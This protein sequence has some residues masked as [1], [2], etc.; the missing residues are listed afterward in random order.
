MKMVKVEICRGTS[1]H[2]LGSQDLI[3]AVES[4]P[5]DRRVQI[6]LGTIDCLKSCRQ[7]PNVRIDGTVFSEKSSEQLRALLDEQTFPTGD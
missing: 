2:L 4:L 6:D 1:C 3:E 7:G 5:V